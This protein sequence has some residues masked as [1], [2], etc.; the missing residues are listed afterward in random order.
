MR[1]SLL[2]LLGDTLSVAEPTVIQY[3]ELGFRDFLLRQK[4]I[5]REI[6]KGGNMKLAIKERLI[7]IPDKVEGAYG[8][9]SGTS[10][11]T[12]YANIYT[13]GTFYK[14]NVK[15]DVLFVKA[16]AFF[17]GDQYNHFT[18]A[19]KKGFANSFPLKKMPS[20]TT[21]GP[22]GSTSLI[23]KTS[24]NYSG[25]ARNNKSGGFFYRLSG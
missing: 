12:T 1:C 7:Q 24:K 3:M 2:H 5:Y 4:V 6:E 23:L 15:R 20:A 19:D 10:A 13:A 21:S 9:T 22:R 16:Q 17:I 18:R 14:L 8:T 11:I 25:F